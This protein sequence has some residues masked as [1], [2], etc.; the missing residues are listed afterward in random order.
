MS[1]RREVLNRPQPAAFLAR[2]AVCR[3]VDALWGHGPYPQ[4]RTRPREPSRGHA[5]RVRMAARLGCAHARDTSGGCA[6][7][8][9][10]ALRS[11]V[12]VR[13]ARHRWTPHRRGAAGPESP[14]IDA[15]AAGPT[16]ARL[17][18]AHFRTGALRQAAAGAAPDIEAHTAVAAGVLAR[19][20]P[21]R[22]G[23]C[24][25]FAHYRVAHPTLTRPAWTIGA[26][27]PF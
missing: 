2:Y 18:V 17:A 8:H 10:G 19:T 15:S 25:F 6:G 23:R 26:V 11:T 3:N 7:T 22:T 5:E 1:R 21:R 27:Q 14:G 24:L 16:G 9:A 13:R 4:T 12:R 20:F